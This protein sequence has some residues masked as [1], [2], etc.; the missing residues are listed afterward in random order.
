MHQN[1]L[2][3]ALLILEFISLFIALPLVFYFDVLP[4]PKIPALVVF[5]LFCLVILVTD[6]TFETSALL[7]WE[8]EASYIRVMLIRFGLAFVL[9]LVATWVFLPDQLF[10]IPRER[11]Q[12]WL[13]IMVFYPLVSALPQELIYRSYFFHRFKPIF[14]R[15]W[16][17]MMA[18]IACFSFLHIIYD[19]A[20]ALIF[21]AVGGYLFTKT[22][23]DTKSL[24]AASLEHALYGCAVFT[25][26]LGGFFY[27]AFTG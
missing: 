23:Q 25:V 10:I 13:I 19:N 3:K 18:S 11:P 17:L 26:G 27:E 8:V 9:L 4:V 7:K 22:Y 5:T 20:V 12:L 16:I 21:T 1:N 15:S 2:R 24:L 14:S 6:R